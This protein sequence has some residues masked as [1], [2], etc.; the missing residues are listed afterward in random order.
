M[1]EEFE[2]MHNA[3]APAGKKKKFGGE[4]IHH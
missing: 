4:F 1:I 2:A 3:V